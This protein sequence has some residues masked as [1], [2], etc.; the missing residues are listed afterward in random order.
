MALVKYAGELSCELVYNTGNCVYYPGDYHRFESFCLQAVQECREPRLLHHADWVASLLHGHRDSSD[1]NNA[2]K[3]GYDPAA[4]A[5][6]S[7]LIAQVGFRYSPF[8]AA[9]TWM[10]HTVA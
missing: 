7:W 2:L 9:A 8:P 3:L 4:E 1:W 6:P 10:T 5:Y